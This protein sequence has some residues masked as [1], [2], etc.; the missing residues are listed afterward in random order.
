MINSSC[1]VL[2][3]ASS[4]KRAFVTGGSG[5]IGGYLVRHLAQD[6]WE[7]HALSRKGKVQIED[8]PATTWYLYDGSYQSISAAIQQASPK[9]L[10]NEYIPGYLL[11]FSGQLFLGSR[12]FDT[13]GIQ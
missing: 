13:V 9:I 11:S 12:R 4:C 6:G 10:S 5:F 8:L 3:S 1:E 7:V 2:G